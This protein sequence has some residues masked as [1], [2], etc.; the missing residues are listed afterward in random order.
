MKKMSAP[1]VTALNAALT[2]SKGWLARG[3]RGSV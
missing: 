1:N 3:V 2:A